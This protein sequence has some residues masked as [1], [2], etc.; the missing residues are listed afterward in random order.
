MSSR[1]RPFVI[2]DLLVNEEAKKK[3]ELS[4][5]EKNTKATPEETIKALQKFINSQ[6][7]PYSLPVGKFEDRKWHGRD[8]QGKSGHCRRQLEFW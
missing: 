7:D 8:Q 6:V 1:S 5:I 2:A 3:K 4:T